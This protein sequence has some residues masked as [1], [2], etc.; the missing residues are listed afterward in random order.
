MDRRSMMDRA[1]LDQIAREHMIPRK[2]HAYRETGW[3]YYHGARTAKLA[4]ALGK[5]IFP[6]GNVAVDTLYA[7]ALF[8]D[9]GKGDEPHSESGSRI[10]RETLNGILPLDQLESVSTLI[11][12]HNLRGRT[13]LELSNES[14]LLMDADLIDH[15]GSIN[16]W[17]GFCYTYQEG[18]GLDDQIDYFESE[19]LAEL[20]SWESSTWFDI[21]RKVLRERNDFV[22]SFMER[23]KKEAGGGICQRSF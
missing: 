1:A 7:A 17:L 10:V 22:E 2:S 11:A 19:G 20:R 5:Q 3:L 21:S 16:I 4:L 6:D 14:K 23:L 15:T 9:V 13:D 12:Q 8:H 18:N